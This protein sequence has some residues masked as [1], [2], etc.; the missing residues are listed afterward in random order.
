MNIKIDKKIITKRGISKCLNVLDKKVDNPEDSLQSI[1]YVL[2]DTELFPN[3]DLYDEECSP[4]VTPYNEVTRGDVHRAEAVLIDDM[5][6]FLGGYDEYTVKNLIQQIGKYLI[7]TD[8]Y[9]E[10]PSKPKKDIT[11]EICD[12]L[13]GADAD[14]AE[15]ILSRSG[16]V[17]FCDEK[18]D[19]G[20]DDDSEDE[21]LMM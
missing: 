6:S 20:L 19:E 12:N 13:I 10:Q 5:D 15:D 11:P 4:I 9:S 2:L 18:F 16:D 7:D 1:G 14:S 8:L 17:R 21:Y 3:E